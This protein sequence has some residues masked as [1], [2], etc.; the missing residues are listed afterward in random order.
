MTPDDRLLRACREG[1]P[2]ST[3]YRLGSCAMRTVA[4]DY[5]HTLDEV[6]RSLRLT[7]QN[8][9]TACALTL[10]KFIY[11]LAALVGDAQML[12]RF[13]CH[14]TVAQRAVRPQ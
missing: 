2:W 13:G 10:G 4:L 7:R 9:W 8:A 6:G 12:E 1:A 5:P 14:P 3:Y 11:R